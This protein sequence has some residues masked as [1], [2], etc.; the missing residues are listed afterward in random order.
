MNWIQRTKPRKWIIDIVVLAWNKGKRKSCKTVGFL[1]APW[2]FARASIVELRIRNIIRDIL[3]VV[4]V[5]FVA[6][7]FDPS[8]GLKVGIIVVNS[9]PGDCATA[10]KYWVS[11]RAT[12]HVSSG[13]RR[14]A[15]PGAVHFAAPLHRFCVILH[16]SEQLRRPIPYRLLLIVLQPPFACIWVLYKKINELH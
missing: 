14:G 10:V 16:C 8:R 1:R 13:V 5:K 11:K 2:V 15:H 3:C 4:T 7:G 9:H 6:E 12:S